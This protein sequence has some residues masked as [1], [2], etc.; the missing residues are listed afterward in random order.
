[1]IYL[2]GKGGPVLIGKAGQALRGAGINQIA[3]NGGR[4]SKVL[5]K[6]GVN[7]VARGGSTFVVGSNGTAT[8]VPRAAGLLERSPI[9]RNTVGRIPGGA[10]GNIASGASKVAG[11]AAAA[12]TVD[13]LFDQ[14]SGSPGIIRHLTMVPGGF[15][16]YRE[17]TQKN[18]LY[19]MTP[20]GAG[21][22]DLIDYAN[23]Q[24]AL[25]AQTVDAY[26]AAGIDLNGP[27]SV[28]QKFF[29][30]L[31]QVAPSLSQQEAQ[32]LFD[33]WRAINRN[34]GSRDLVIERASQMENQK[35]QQMMESVIGKRQVIDTNAITNSYNNLLNLY[36]QAYGDS[37]AALRSIGGA[38]VADAN[39]RAGAVAGQYRQAAA[40][41]SAIPGVTASYMDRGSADSLRS[42]EASGIGTGGVAEARSVSDAFAG[43]MAAALA[44][45]A[46]ANAGNY[47]MYGKN[48][49]QVGQMMSEAAR[50][51]AK[52]N[53]QMLL[54]QAAQD[55]AKNMNDS[56][57]QQA[58]IDSNYANSMMNYMKLTG[59]QAGAID[60]ARAGT[61]VQD[62]LG[63]AT[64]QE[65][66][67][68]AYAAT[69]LT[70]DP[71]AARQVLED[72]DSRGMLTPLVQEFFMQYGYVSG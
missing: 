8:A 19:D 57:V 24:D 22:N 14:Y 20:W 5:G 32:T 72:L 11:P 49:G 59:Q 63:R 9:L 54:A 28:R 52:G 56:Q 17:G 41:Y 46:E 51:Q 12:L 2:V 68:L 66:Q 13:Q 65:Q 1:M 47:T 64:P 39:A 27:D 4:L 36:E 61:L 10:G 21:T 48:A 26:K 40:D 3:G 31:A 50:E 15:E 16:G 37:S 35:R 43:A 69:V 53:L 67:A 58:Q 30:D 33:Q 25:N 62:Y 42:L 70:T 29:F 38:A 34:E 23:T 18:R 45:E 60:P 7:S 44:R 55:Y 6:P 71:K